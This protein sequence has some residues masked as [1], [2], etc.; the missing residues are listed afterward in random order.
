MI[1]EFISTIEQTGVIVIA[2]EISEK[3]DMLKVAQAIFEGGVRAF[4][5]AF[6]IESDEK[7]KKVA[8][9]MKEL[10]KEYGEEIFIGAGAVLTGEQIMLAAES[11]ADFIVSA[12]VNPDIIDKT[13]ASRLVSIPGAYTPTEI[14]L[15]DRCGAHFVKV[16]PACQLG[17]QYFTTIIPQLNYIRLLAYGGITLENFKRFLI[18]GACG[19]GAGSTL[20]NDRYI[21][22]GNYKTITNMAKQFIRTKQEILQAKEKAKKLTYNL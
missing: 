8:E 12:N 20:V 2:R 9:I 13:L 7:T 6:D 14:A 16:F 10:R 17:E 3:E 15:A 1:N 19:A 11:G 22:T 4:E 18:A 5:L 21:S